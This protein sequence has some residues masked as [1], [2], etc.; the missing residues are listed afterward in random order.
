[1][2]LNHLHLHV[3]DVARSQAFYCKY[4]GLREQ[5]WHGRILFMTDDHGFDL[6]LAPCDEVERFPPWFHFGFRLDS[7]E[8]VRQLAGE[9][10]AASIRLV[11]ELEED[12][13]L[14]SFRCVDPDG[15]TIEVYWE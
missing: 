1:M 3:A 11:Q 9:L 7:A 14:V 8:R 13:G 4:F 12:D 2:Q 6:A 15:Y 10:E 5:V